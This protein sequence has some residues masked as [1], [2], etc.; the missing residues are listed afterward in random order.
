[1]VYAERDMARVLIADDSAQLRLLVRR[2]L[3]HGGHEVLEAVDGEAALGVLRAE[4][5]D[6]AVLDVEM[7]GP[8]GLDV[9]RAIRGD[10]DLAAIRLI[11]L[12]ANASSA[13]AAEAGADRFVAKPFLASTLLAAVRDLA[14]AGRRGHSL[15]RLPPG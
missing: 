12:S 10:A 13:Q 1:M 2:V 3:Q 7:P 14:V 9:C 5:P 4:R 15:D 11:I 8:S 6:V